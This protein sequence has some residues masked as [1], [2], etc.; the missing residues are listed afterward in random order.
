MFACNLLRVLFPHG[1]LLGI[2][3]G[4]TDA[5][6]AD[7]VAHPTAVQRHVHALLESQLP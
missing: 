3:R 1:V 4:G 7:D 2:N 5:Q 6:D